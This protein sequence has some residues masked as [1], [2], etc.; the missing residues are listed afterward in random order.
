MRPTVHTSAGFLAVDASL[1]DVVV[2][3]MSPSSAS[4]GIDPGDHEGNRRKVVCEGLQ[5]R[6]H[7]GSMLNGERREVHSIGYL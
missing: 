1:T 4:C 3:L 5:I 2:S 6:V 7:N